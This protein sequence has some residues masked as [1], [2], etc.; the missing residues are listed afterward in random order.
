ML[1]F[2][3]S[4]GNLYSSGTSITSDSF[5]QITEQEYASALSFMYSQ[6]EV[7]APSNFGDLVF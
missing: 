1:Y 5:I 6:R 2:Y 4:N 7:G 3:N